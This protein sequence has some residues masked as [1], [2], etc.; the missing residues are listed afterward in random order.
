MLY[1]YDCTKLSGAATHSWSG[2][3]KSIH[4]VDKT[5]TRLTK[6]I[7]WKENVWKCIQIAL[8][9]YYWWVHVMHGLGEEHYM[10]TPSLIQKLLTYLYMNSLSLSPPLSLSLSLSLLP[11][12]TWDH[13]ILEGDP[14]R[15]RRSL[16]HVP[17]LPPDTDPW[18]VPLNDKSSESLTSWC[19]RLCR[20]SQQKIPVEESK[21]WHL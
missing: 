9:M 14:A 8:L 5:S 21:V 4:G 7:L 3:V 1:S 10:Y 6:D 18:T 2:S 15:V 20:S 13:Y 12:L 11:Y 19:N 17:L 16:S